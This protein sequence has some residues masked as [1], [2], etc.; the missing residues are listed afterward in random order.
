MSSAN[1]FNV[2]KSK[3]SNVVWY[4]VKLQMNIGPKFDHRNVTECRCLIT[5]M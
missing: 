5:G 2:E 3:I 4:R 1:V